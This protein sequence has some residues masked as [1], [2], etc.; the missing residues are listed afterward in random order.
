MAH[1]I[2]DFDKVSL[3]K[4]YNELIL[5]NR[6]GMQPISKGMARELYPGL[7]FLNSAVSHIHQEKSSC[8]VTTDK[9]KTF[10]AKKV[11][12]SIPTPLYKMIAFSPALSDAKTKLAASTKL[13]Y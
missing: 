3:E 9:G 2:S 1:S 11:M 8:I 10:R 7:L 4:Y 13:G 12:I 5:F 6:K